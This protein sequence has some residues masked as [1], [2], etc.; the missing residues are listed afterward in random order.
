MIECK[1][2]KKTWRDGRPKRGLDKTWIKEIKCKNDDL[3]RV[4]SLCET[5]IELMLMF[6]IEFLHI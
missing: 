4:A 2:K 5:K 6:M 1:K 3:V